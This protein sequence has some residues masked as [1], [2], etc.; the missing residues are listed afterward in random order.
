ML[1]RKLE[2]DILVD[3]QKY[4]ED[5][6]Y[7]LPHRVISQIEEHKNISFNFLSIHH[8]YGKQAINFGQI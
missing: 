6:N 3:I 4:L 1:D 8:P 5:V 2:D 7:G